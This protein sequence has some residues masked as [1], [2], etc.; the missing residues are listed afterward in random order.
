M[1]VLL[2]L[3]NQLFE[4]NKLITK[5]SHVYLYEHP[6]F[7]TKYKYH[8]L[9]LILHRST[10]KNYKDYIKEKYKC[11]VTY[12]EYHE[13]F[14]IK[15]KKLNMYDPVDHSIIKNLK[16]YSKDNNFE[17]FV[18]DT[19]LFV[20]PLKE[21]NTYLADGG[22]YHQTTFYIWQRKRLNILINK[23]LKPIGGKWTYDTKNRLPFPKD[24]NE[25]N[26]PRVNN[27]KYVI[28]ATKYVNKHFSGNYGSDEYY[29]PTDFTASKIHFKKFIKHKLKC[30]GPYQ[31]AV[32]ENVIFGCHS[33]ISPLLNIG[34]LTP[35]YVID[36]VLKYY[37]KY[38]IKL[39]SIEGYIRQIIGWREIVRMTYMFKHNEMIH[40]N[41]FN[42]V[43]KLD[44]SWYKGNTG[45]VVIDNLIHK[46]LKYSYTHHI[47]RLMYLGNFMLLTE[48]APKDMYKWF[49]TLYIDS[50]EWVMEANVYAMSA[51]S[52][53]PLL[54][55]R[56]YFSSSNYINNMSSYKKKMN[57]YPKINNYEWF[58]VWDALYYNFI[59]NNKTIFAKNYAI[60]SSVSN[61]N[62][63]SKDEQQKLLKIAKW[64]LNNY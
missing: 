40:T 64:Y 1:N 49:M 53:G 26:I 11:N 10:M 58:E 62:K 48:V 19:P 47:E 31:D 3:P 45:I 61:W 28:E 43:R 32:D 12:I 24:F 54:M 44:D 60:A 18:H 6:I 39:E 41:Y 63:K 17:L 5:A 56:P 29:L 20:T 55:T 36:L 2:I 4:N 46:L 21:F 59:N 16:E 42:H 14:N 52:T 7:F 38:N 25:T 51:Y 30:F 22:T 8:K 37:K 50:Y 57:V 9:K 23:D 35:K 33:I 13:E 34:L 15:C 27:N